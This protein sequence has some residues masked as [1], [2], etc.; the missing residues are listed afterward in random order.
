[1]DFESGKN[2]EG[3]AT[4]VSTR[5]FGRLGNELYQYAAVIGYAV[6]HGLAFSFPRKTNDATWNPT[7]MPHLYHPDWVEGRE[8]VLLNEVWN[9]DQHYQE[10]PFKHEWMN[11]QI[12]LNGYWQSYKYFDHCRDLV[13]KTFAFPWKMEKGV[14]SIHVRRGD[15]LLYPTKHPVVTLEYLKKAISFFINEGYNKFKFFSDDIPWC[16]SI[17]WTVHYPGCEFEY[18]VGRNEIEDLV[19]MSCC[20]HNICS[21]STMAVWAAELNRNHKKI[22]IVPSESNWFGPENPYTVKDM[23]RPSWKQITYA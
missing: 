17:G 16:I 22:V 21:N 2:W 11:S 18:S 23:F 6:K 19:E 4:M 10:I 15:Y 9:M 20:E 8:D 14:V 7:H 3:I 1:M 13:L 5:R 12:V